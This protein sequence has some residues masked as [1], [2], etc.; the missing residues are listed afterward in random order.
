[1][2]NLHPQVWRDSVGGPGSTS[3]YCLMYVDRS[4]LSQGCQDEGEVTTATLAGQPDLQAMVDGDNEAFDAELK[5]W[6]AKVCALVNCFLFSFYGFSA[7]YF[8]LYF[9]IIFFL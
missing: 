3:A 7:V 4:R 9:I 6:D 1:M 8:L 2:A 5:A